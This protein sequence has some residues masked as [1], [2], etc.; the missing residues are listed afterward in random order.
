MRSPT[1]QRDPTAQSGNSIARA[2]LRVRETLL[3]WANSGWAGPAAATWAFLQSSIVPGP[4]DAV[5]LP[6]GLAQPQ[7]APAL[8]FW[9]TA[10]AMAGGLTAY[11]IGAL[12]FNSVGLAVLNALNIPASEFAKF[13]ALFAAKGWLIIALGSLPILSAKLIAIAAGAFGFPVG[14]F[15]LVSFL[16]RGVRFISMGFILRFGGPYIQRWLQR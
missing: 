6:F 13:E 2:T 14:K 15:L 5:V 8:G 12:A 16:V 11:T 1:P 10:G 7:R 9:T 3:R 4:S